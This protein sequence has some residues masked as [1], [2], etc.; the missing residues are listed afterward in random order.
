MIAAATGEKAVYPKS[1]FISL[2]VVVQRTA[3]SVNGAFWDRSQLTVSQQNKR[4][5]LG[6]HLSGMSHN[7]ILFLMCR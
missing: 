3:A 4:H 7:S 6:A 2:L 5:P 1:V